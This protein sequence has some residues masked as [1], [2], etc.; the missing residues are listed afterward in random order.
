MTGVI[1]AGGEGIRLRP[2]TH[3]RPKPMMPIANKPL[4]QYQIELLKK[5]GVTNI[6]LCVRNGVD[7][8]ELHLA[9][10]FHSRL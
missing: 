3:T 2:L 10:L 8:I 4:L 5:H 1:I 6:V 7:K 9:T